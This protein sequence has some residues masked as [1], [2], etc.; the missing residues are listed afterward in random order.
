MIHK[1]DNFLFSVL[2]LSTFFILYFLFVSDLVF[3]ANLFLFLQARSRTL[4]PFSPSFNIN[5]AQLPFKNTF[6]VI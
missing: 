5:Q 4:G 2:K 3:P 6:N 1:T